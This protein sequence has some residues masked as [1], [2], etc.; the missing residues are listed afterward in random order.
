[1]ALELGRST[2]EWRTSLTQVA[3]LACS[4][5]DKWR[6]AACSLKHALL[7]DRDA[8]IRQLCLGRKLSVKPLSAC[9]PTHEVAKQV[10]C[11]D[12]MV[13]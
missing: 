9:L 11:S 7:I 4:S 12:V 5:E 6:C 13:F 3:S 1:M 10:R 8:I 2:S